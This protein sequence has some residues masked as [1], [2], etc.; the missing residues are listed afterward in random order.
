MARS[1]MTW[2]PALFADRVSSAF[3]LST[4]QLS[5]AVSFSCCL[6]T[7]ANI[8]LVI[9]IEMLRLAAQS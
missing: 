3:L 8:S 9:C 1:C 5:H 7:L 6:P 2:K 4:S